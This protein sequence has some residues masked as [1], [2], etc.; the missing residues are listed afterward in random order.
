MNW[1][2]AFTAGAFG[3]MILGVMTRVALGHTGRP[4]RIPPIVTISYILVSAAALI[5]V[6]GPWLAEG[7]YTNVLAASIAA[8]V[9]AFV[10]FLAAYAP[11][12]L[13]PRVDGRPG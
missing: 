9:A 2:H 10:I 13:R 6:F 12:L 7:R 5:R 11:I 8:W 4:L 1:M 3:T